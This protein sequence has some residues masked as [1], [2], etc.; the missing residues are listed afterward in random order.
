[1][2]GSSG[3]GAPA[4]AVAHVLSASLGLQSLGFTLAKPPSVA[5]AACAATTRQSIRYRLLN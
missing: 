2:S 1:M 3:A 4:T 5:L